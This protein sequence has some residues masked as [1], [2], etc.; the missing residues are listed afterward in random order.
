MKDLKNLTERH[1]TVIRIRAYEIWELEGRPDGRHVEHWLKAERDLRPSRAMPSRPARKASAAA[2]KARA[3][4]AG[5]ATSRGS[6]EG[7]S[8]RTVARNP[9]GGR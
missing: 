7:Q 1:R 9:S 6:A 3:D 4:G 5:R 2:E 8:W